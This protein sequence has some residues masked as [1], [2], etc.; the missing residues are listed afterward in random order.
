MAPIPVLSAKYSSYAQHLNTL[1]AL[2]Y[3]TTGWLDGEVRVDKEESLREYSRPGNGTS[4]AVDSAERLLNCV[5][6]AYPQAY[7]L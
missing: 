7:Y 6:C 3:R 2:S 1:T 5:R 4:S